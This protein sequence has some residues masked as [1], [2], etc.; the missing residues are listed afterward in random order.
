MEG[1]GWVAAGALAFTHQS[2]LLLLTA[3]L[4]IELIRWTTFKKQQ[5]LQGLSGVLLEIRY[6]LIIDSDTLACVKCLFYVVVGAV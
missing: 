5:Q 1:R 2:H 3:L 6:S 4:M